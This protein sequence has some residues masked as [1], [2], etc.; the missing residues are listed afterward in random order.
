MDNGLLEKLSK[1]RDSAYYPFHMPGHKRRMPEEIGALRD[2][3]GLDITEIE[4]FDNL[5]QPEGILREANRRAARVF[6]AEETCMLVNGSTAG[7]LT[8]VSAAVPRGGR[9]IM[10]RNC[11]RA[12][13]HA[14]YLRELDPVYLYPD[15]VPGYGIADCIR[16]EQVAAAV[17]EY[18]A[19]AAVLITS[20]TYD[21]VVSDVEAIAEIVHEAG[22]VLIVDAAHGA[23]FG[24]AEGWPESPVRL[25]A[26]LVIQSL[27]K[28]LPALTQTA[29]LHMNGT[30]VDRE[31]V[32]RFECIYQTSS[33]S[34]LLMGSIDACVRLMEEQGRSL[35]EGFGERLE[36]FRERL[37]RLGVLRLMN[38]DILDRGCM[39][40]FDQGKLLIYTG[41]SNLTGNFLY[42]E[43]INR[44]YFQM[45]M[46]CD[47][48]V[49][50]IATPWD[51][52]E[53]L[54]RLADALLGID[55]RLEPVCV[56]GTE[57][58]APYPG[59]RTAVPLYRAVDAPKEERTLRE[60]A[61][62][63]SGTYVNLYPPGIP[64]AV[65]GEMLEEEVIKLIERYMGQG[66]HVQG[67]ER[68]FTIKLLK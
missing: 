12:V 66:L 54:E 38:E 42:K 9:L 36:H 7:I 56:A 13:Y 32:R 35:M 67:V 6:G 58:A 1:Y 33:P 46:A 39:K 21:G 3:A 26:D 50:A 49:T 8:A 5:H 30:R 2:V 51:S 27:H 14:V 55:S 65:P 25:G 48:Y 61:G 11:H 68:S 60:A 45:E 22:M 64:L 19:A 59:L 43:L 44:Y 16:P 29:L 34:Y 31:A 37:R 53:G 47:T 24:F 15:A 41:K 40:A 10:A 57:K 52:K 20:P 4:G 63:V 18:P 17:K 23:H 62:R 28:T